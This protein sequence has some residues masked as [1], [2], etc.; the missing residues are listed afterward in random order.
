MLWLGTWH[1]DE[2]AYFYKE[3]EKRATVIRRKQ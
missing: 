3:D 2:R 1:N